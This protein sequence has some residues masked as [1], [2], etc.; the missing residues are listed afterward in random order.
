M[1]QRLL[2][3]LSFFLFF[4]APASIAQQPNSCGVI[5]RMSPEGDSV[6]TTAYT[7]VTFQ[8]ISTNATSYTFYV[9]GYYWGAN[10]P[11]NLDIRPGLT[12]IMLVA[13][14]GTC[15]DTAVAYYFFSGTFPANADNYSINIGLHNRTMLMKSLTTLKNGNLLMAGY[16]EYSYDLKEADMGVLICMKPEGC[17][18]WARRIPAEFPLGARILSAKE[19]ADGGLLLLA[20]SISEYTRYVIKLD[21]AGN[22]LWSKGL[23]DGS[24]LD[25][26]IRNIEPTP[27]GGCLLPNF[28]IY[29]YSVNLLRLD[30]S[31]QLVWQH[32]IDMGATNIVY[33]SDMLLLDGFIYIS[34]SK[35]SPN[36]VF[37]DGFI[38]KIRL[39]DGALVWNRTWQSANGPV[40]P[41]QMVQ[42]DSSIVANMYTPTGQVNRPS[43]GGYLRIDTAGNFRSAWLL[44]EIHTPGPVMDPF[45]QTGSQMIRSGNSLY[46]NTYGYHPLPLQGDGRQSVQFRLDST[47]KLKWVISEG[48]IAAQRLFYITPDTAGGAFAGGFYP[49]YT[50]S[51][52]VQ[53]IPFAV[54][55][56]DSSG[57]D[58]SGQC[59]KYH[60]PCEEIIPVISSSSVPWSFNQQ[61]ILQLYNQVFIFDDLYPE[62]RFNC[63]D[64][65]DSC[66]YLKVEGKKGICNISQ[67][68][69]YKS[70]RNKACGQPTQWT[71]SAGIQLITQTDSSVTVKFL[72]LGRHV[73]YGRNKLSCVP[74]QDSIVIVAA[75]TTPAPD[76]GPDLSICP[77]NTKILHAGTYYARYEWQDGSTDSL[78]S[79]SQPGLY[80][81][82]VTD[83][84]DNVFNDT[85]LVVLAPPVPF[86]AGPDQSICQYDTTTLTATAGFNSY[87][88]G[89]DYRI[90]SLN[91][92]AV[93]VS[94]L[95]DTQYTVKAELTPGCFAYDTV[96]ITVNGVMPFTLGRDTSICK[97][98]SI[99]LIAGAGYATYQWSTGQLQQQVTVKAAGRY[100]VTATTAAGCRFSDTIAL[101]SLYD[102]PQPRLNKSNLLCE[103]QSRIL[104]PG[105]GYRNYLWN[106]GSQL[107][108]LTVN[109]T[110]TY[111]VTVSDQNG[112]S[113]SDTTVISFIQANPA[114]FLP[115]DTTICQYDKLLITPLK[116]FISYN[117]STGSIT[118]SVTVAKSGMYRLEVKDQYGCTGNDTINVLVRTDCLN[119]VF[120]PTAF[121]PNGD[122]RNDSFRPLVFGKITSYTFRIFNRWGQLVYQSVN[123]DAG[124]NGKLAN[125]DQPTGTFTWSLDYSLEGQPRKQ[126][127]GTVVLIR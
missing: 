69:T 73:I 41:T 106:N 116:T 22:F 117:W 3:Y 109:G 103:G 24:G 68:Y 33:L 14:N 53:G 84:C 90:S 96:R 18:Q 49:G 42:L 44:S 92:A 78:L 121:T 75:S 19:A 12:K 113:G 54:M 27:D 38:G 119:G 47:Y 16:R 46:W 29:D 120:V 82:K 99:T 80:W 52:I 107:Q 65:V 9:D 108:T 43:L 26:N 7:M 88:W 59:Y 64:Y 77:G 98:D 40:L 111:A 5:A 15:S 74:V 93:K 8:S 114:G 28:S 11:I 23:K 2:V 125:A 101:L 110:G 39:A 66:S 104:D 89:P 34:G 6:V 1:T 32:Y 21:A 48:G 95:V 79:I 115:P 10:T 51:G 122:G 71:L 91:T 13:T 55:P 112:C 37:Y 4:L 61:G 70:H 94:P 86:T 50:L 123:P 72:N 63:P 31:G 67:T 60:M 58:P 56:I 62:L 100:S 76:L 87:S 35:P 20:S 124:W 83:S 36:S 45:V 97:G 118:A 127:Q 25:R 81:V 85:L 105:A 30:A 126:L 17:V 102:L 57:D